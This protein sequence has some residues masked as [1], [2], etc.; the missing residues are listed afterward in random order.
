[1]N[2]L[3]EIEAK[4]EKIRKEID[5]RKSSYAAAVEVAELAEL[6]RELARHLARKE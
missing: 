5:K 1:V 3:E 6:V 4:A 2:L